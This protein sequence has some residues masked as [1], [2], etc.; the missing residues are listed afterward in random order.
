[1]DNA[2]Q[3]QNRFSSQPEI[4]KQFLEI[5]QT[6]QRESKPIHDVYAQVTH[7]FNGAPDLLE[8]FKQFLP[9]SA[10]HA[11]AAREKAA[12]EELNSARGEYGGHNQTPR[13]DH[14]RLPPMGQFAPTPANREGKRKRGADRHAIAQGNSNVNNQDGGKNGFVPHKVSR[15]LSSSSPSP[16]TPCS[17]QCDVLRSLCLWTLL[18]CSLSLPPFKLPTLLPVL[19]TDTHSI[20]H[21]TD[22]ITAGE[23]T[24]NRAANN[25]I[26]SSTRSANHRAELG[27][28]ATR[29]NATFSCCIR[30]SR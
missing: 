3:W 6:Y 21:C 5:L 8:D 15:F 28:C 26:P 23:A 1:M 19:P 12:A 20:W 10:A 30:N 29:A 18:A 14:G 11:K 16:S 4:Y 7:L 25:E 17:T 24:S 22:R 9:E 2:H 27:S 13:A